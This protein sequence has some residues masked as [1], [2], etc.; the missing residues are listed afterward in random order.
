MLTIP[1]FVC[2]AVAL[3]VFRS[4]SDHFKRRGLF[5]VT[6]FAIAALGYLL[7]LVGNSSQ[8]PSFAA[9]FLVG[10]GTYPCVV[11]TLAWVN[12]N[13]ICYTRR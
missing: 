3:L 2:A 7:L 13:F 6:V 5:L 12:S 11:I 9:T 1:V 4:L 10:I 8:R